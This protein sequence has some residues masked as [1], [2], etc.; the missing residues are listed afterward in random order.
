ML[1]FCVLPGHRFDW[2]RQAPGT[3]CPVPRH[4]GPVG[5][6]LTESYDWRPAVNQAGIGAAE[7]VESGPCCQEKPGVLSPSGQF[8]PHAALTWSGPPA[9]RS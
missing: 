3:R 8:V 2:I 5:G 7:P 9:E 6:Y 1:Q 4:D